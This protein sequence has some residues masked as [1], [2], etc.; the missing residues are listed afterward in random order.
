MLTERIYAISLFA[1]Q[2]ILLLL[3]LT[4]IA[5]IAIILERYFFIR[6]F[7]KTSQSVSSTLQAIVHNNKIDDIESIPNDPFSLEGQAAANSLKYLKDRGSKGL[8]EFFNTFVITQRPMIE[9]G[10]G[11][12]ATVGSNAPYVGLLGTVFGIMKAFRE[13]SLAGSQANS[14]VMI[15]EGISMALVAT[16]AGLFV[17][18]PAVVAYNVYNRKI[19]YIYDNLDALK[20]I[21][22]AYAKQKGL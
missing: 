16:G 19:R 14:Q 17:A 6:K 2:A 5:S 10:M 20:E 1:D 15:M 21:L 3:L 8:E 11:F 7:S 13:L 12:L 9:K 4:S 18:I 22:L